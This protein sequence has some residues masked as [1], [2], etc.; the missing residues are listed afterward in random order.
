MER[1]VSDATSV[2]I[3]GVGVVAGR[4]CG[5]DALDAVLQGDT[6]LASA[7][8]RVTPYHRGDG[9]VLGVVSNVDLS[10]WLS[11]AA[12][13]RMGR[14]S[15]FAA[16]AAQMAVLDAGHLV[17]DGATTPVVMSTAF[18]AVEATE[19]LQRTAHADGPAAVSPFAF[20]E[21]VANAPA[22]HIAMALGAHGPNV[23][24]AQR[25][26][27]VLTAVGRGAMEI[28]SGRAR[29]AVVG[30]AEEL[31]PVLHAFLDRFDALARSGDGR[32]EMARPF[33]RY[34]N[35]FV[36]AE[37]AA[38]LLLE[39]E[40]DAR[41]RGARIRARIRGFASAFDATAARIGWGHGHVTLGA[42]LT[43]LLAR[44][45]TDRARIRR[46]VSGASGAV[47]GD[48]LEARVLHQVWDGAALPV[49]LAP[50]GHT[51]EYGGGF[52]AAAVLG[53]TRDAAGATAG[54]DTADP[55]LDLIPHRGGVLPAAD[56]TLVSSLASG[57]AASW[58]L[59]ETA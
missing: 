51:G 7:V 12:S 46:V 29:C 55:A 22:A 38:V 34:R 59:L 57:G 4:C 5:I 56:V 44:T 53:A 43:R 33:D 18:G 13:R 20:T 35:G 50:K 41:A 16:A 1:I 40:R 47:S 31:P 17:I 2:V 10:A 14:P 19:Q 24:I 52:L 49:V 3:T 28:A 11:P 6:P 45:T 25:E 37:G 26:A 21:S 30:C 36:A 39:D 58:L 9:A 8:E 48:R 15:R 32:A 23:T 42:A 54:F 27:G